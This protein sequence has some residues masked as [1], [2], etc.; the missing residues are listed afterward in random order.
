M[1]FMAPQHFLSLLVQHAHGMW[2]FLT[3]SGKLYGEEG[4][5]YGID[6]LLD[7]P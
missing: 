4:L 7:L 3:I 1:D 6:V 5:E 2:K